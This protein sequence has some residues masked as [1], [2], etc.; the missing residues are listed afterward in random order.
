[1]LAN[2]NFP[3]RT[4]ENTQ[5]KNF[6]K[7]RPVGAEFLHADGQTDIHTDRWTERH[8]EANSRFSQICERTK[9]KEKHCCDSLCDKNCPLFACEVN[10]LLPS[11]VSG[12]RIVDKIV[13]LVFSYDFLPSRRHT[14]W[15]SPSIHEEQ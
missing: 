14:S 15:C 7:I 5:I 12:F 9:K 10:I 8:G 11:C 2:L 6:M 1:M 13:Y 4:S 3:E